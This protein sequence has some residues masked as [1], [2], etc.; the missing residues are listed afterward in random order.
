MCVDL[1]WNHNSLFN[2]H[3]HQFKNILGCLFGKVRQYGNG[4]RDMPLDILK[5]ITI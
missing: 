1:K 3:T 5:I 4:C 2:A